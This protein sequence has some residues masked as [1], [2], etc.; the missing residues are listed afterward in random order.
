MASTSGDSAR[1]SIPGHD[2]QVVFHQLLVGARKTWLTDALREAVAEVDPAELKAQIARHVPAGALRL[3]ARAGIRD[4]DVFPVPV[5]LEAK[6]TLVGYYRLLL[7]ISQK[8]FYRGGTGLGAFK[9]MEEKGVLTE[10]ARRELPELCAALT[11]ALADLVE[12]LAPEVT[13]RDL[14]ELALLT[15]GPTFHGSNNNAIGRQATNDVFVAITEIVGDFVTGGDERKLLL[16]NSASREVGIFLGADPDVRIE[17]RF[18]QGWRKKVAIEIKGG[19]D[20]SNAH[21]R[22]GEAEKSHQKAK[23]DLGFIDFWTIITKR[24][25]WT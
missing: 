2:K 8:E 16:T 11:K 12:R 5:V 1:F 22:A 6:P 9:S 24:R 18:G 10:R 14:S 19:T 13:P 25:D 21:N 20:R 4:E 23:N 3:L 7:G 15:L 17:E